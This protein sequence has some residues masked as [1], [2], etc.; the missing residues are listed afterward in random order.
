MF[1]KSQKTPQCFLQIFKSI[2]LSVKEKKLKTDFKD[3]S[4]GSYLGFPIRI[5][6]N[7]FDLQVTPP[8]ASY[9]VSSQLIFC[10]RRRRKKKNNG[11]HL[12]FLIWTIFIILDLQVTPVLSTKFSI[13]WPFSSGEE[14]KNRCSRWR[15]SWIADP[16]DF[17]CFCSTK[18]PRFFL[19]TFKSVGF[20]VQEKK[21]IRFSG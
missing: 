11:R 3:R 14:E 10:F 15:Q 5:F 9:Q 7:R 19:P 20:S 18:I 13:N 16:N 2:G 12:G 21:R 17:S 1:N 6:S 4:H 8:N